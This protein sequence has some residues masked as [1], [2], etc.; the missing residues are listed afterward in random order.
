M[1]IL[2]LLQ[3]FKIE[4]TGGYAIF[5]ILCVLACVII[6]LAEILKFLVHL[7]GGMFK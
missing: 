7:L 2:Q 4:F 1:K 6:S 3:E 5:A